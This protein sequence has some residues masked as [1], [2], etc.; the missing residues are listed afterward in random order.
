M[1]GVIEINKTFNLSFGTLPKSQY[2]NLFLTSDIETRW[3]ATLLDPFGG[4][5]V[6]DLVKYWTPNE[7][8][9]LLIPFGKWLVLN[10]LIWLFIGAAFFLF[11]MKK[12]SFSKEYKLFGFKGKKYSQPNNDKD[13]SLD[14]NSDAPSRT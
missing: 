2:L 8:D 9:T 5:A 6:G 12:F 4:E 1:Y 13:S 14:I 11:G 3:I 7:R 10:R